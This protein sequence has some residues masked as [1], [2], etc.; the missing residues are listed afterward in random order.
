[1]YYLYIAG[2]FSGRYNTLEDAQAAGE[3]KRSNSIVRVRYGHRSWL[4]VYDGEW[5][6]Q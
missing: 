6:E 3:R 5:F 1:M 4:S 2:D